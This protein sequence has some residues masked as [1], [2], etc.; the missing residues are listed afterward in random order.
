MK[1]LLSPAKLQRAYPGNIQGAL[2]FKKETKLLIQELKH[3]TVSDFADRMK[4]SQ[5]KA[6]ETFEQF[7]Q[8]GKKGNQINAA[9][10]LFAYIGE[11]FKALDAEQ[12]SAQELDYLQANLLILSGLHG[13]LRPFDR[14]EPY[15][16]EMAQRGAAPNGQSLYAFWRAP[17]EKCLLKQLNKDELILNL[18]SSEYS[19]VVQDERLR[20]RFI[21]PHFVEQKNGQLKTVSVFSK[22]ARGTMARWCAARSIESVAAVKSFSE[23]GYVF[24][25]AHSDDCNWYFIR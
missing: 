4:L 25:A 11:A 14:I 13:L 16:L 12:L 10:A 2:L 24:S 3:W 22:Q 1:I 20:A 19:D 8:W 18:A 6:T 9:P 5:D 21:T 17:I 7:Q 15:R 23:M